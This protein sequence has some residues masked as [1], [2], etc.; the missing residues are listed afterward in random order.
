MWRAQHTP[1]GPATVHVRVEADARTVHARAWG[2]GAEWSIAHADDLVGAS[3]DPHAFQPSDPMLRSL[4]ARLPRLRLA[5]TVAVYDIAVAAVIDQRV[6]GREARGTWN[7]LVRRFGTPAPGPTTG[8]PPGLRLLPSPDVL[9]GLGDAA[10]RTL[11]LEMRRG[12]ALS[13]VAADARGLERAATL[14]ADVL[15]RRLQSIAGVGVWTSATVRAYALGDTDAL[16]LGDWHLPHEIGA[17]LAG[18]R[19]ADDARMVEL[20][21]PYRP[22]RFRV[23][24]LVLASGATLARRAPRAEIP[25]LLRKEATGRPFTVRRRLRFE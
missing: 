5:R 20:L 17:A 2:D 15:D 7:A 6:S 19:R 9:A 1:L 3:D 12:V 24:R 23:V 14:G 22:Q 11:G 4:V 16:P 18:E 13:S 8:R 10:R 21:E 25:D